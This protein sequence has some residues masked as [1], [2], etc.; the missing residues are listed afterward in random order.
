MN[1]KE[2]ARLYTVAAFL[3]GYVLIDNLS[4]TEQ[5]ALGNWLMLV[6]QTLC[7]NGSYDFNT[8]WKGHLGS[9]HVDI[10]KM[11]NKMQSSID[12]VNKIIK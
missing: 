10:R 1:K 4:S 3:L 9:G 7:T 8:D 2:E 11:L 6:A 5:N 12:E